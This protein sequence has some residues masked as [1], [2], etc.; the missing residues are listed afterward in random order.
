MSSKSTVMELKFNETDYGKT[1]SHGGMHV[2][3]KQKKEVQK[4]FG[5]NPNNRDKT[6]IV[7]DVDQDN[8]ENLLSFK[9]YSENKSS[10]DRITS[11]NRI[12]HEKG[13]SAGDI[14][15]IEKV[16][17]NNRYSYYMTSRKKEKEI[18][19]QGKGKGIVNIPNKERFNKIVKEQIKKG[20]VTK[21][22]KNTY[23]MDTMFKKKKV[24]LVLRRVKKGYE[25]SIDGKALKVTNRDTYILS[26]NRKYAS[27]KEDEKIKIYDGNAK[28][29]YKQLTNQYN[30]SKGDGVRGSR[31]NKKATAYTPTKE[32]PPRQKKRTVTEWERDA[33]KKEN[34]LRRA[35]NTCSVNKNHKSFLRRDEKVKYMEGH[36]IIPMNL[37]KEMAHSLDVEANIICICGE[38][39]DK[40]HYGNG[41]KLIKKM[42]YDRY[43]DL[44]KAG[45]LELKDGG[46]LTYEMLLEKMGY[47]K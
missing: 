33:E 29:Y 34:V 26:F 30:I 32:G 4:F 46:E 35:E 9:G 1:G 15:I 47:G 18:Y 27:L 25:L 45:C 23:S 42:F 13:L 3:E 40:V 7:I 10:A 20:I 6:I 36:H 22:N 11:F 43:K 24:K 12:V 28:L 14:I 16:K 17:N 38:C 31:L 37:Q 44:K 21:N 2:K 19:M 5:H 39:H 41:E 8:K